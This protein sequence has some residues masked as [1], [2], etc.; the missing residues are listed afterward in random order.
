MYYVSNNTLSNLVLSVQR[1]SSEK[2]KQMLQLN[3]DQVQ[4]ISFCFDTLSLAL[5]LCVCVRVCVLLHTVF[6]NYCADLFTPQFSFGGLKPPLATIREPC[7][8]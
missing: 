3:L 7:N 2:V 5:S 1:Y 6:Y 4:G 8:F